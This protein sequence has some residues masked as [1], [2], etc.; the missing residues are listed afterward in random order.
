MYLKQNF[1]KASCNFW[2]ARLNARDV[3]WRSGL[4][5]GVPPR[6]V[7]AVHILVQFAD[8][9]QH[10]AEHAEMRVAAVHLVVEHDAVKAFARRIGQ[11]FF[12]QRHV[13][14]AGKTE[15]VNDFADLVFRGLDA[16][17]NFHLL[18]A[19]QQR[20][21]A[22]LLEIHPHRIIERVQPARVFLLGVGGFDAIHLRLVH[23]F[24]F[25]RAQLGENLVQ[26]FRGHGIFRQ[27]VVEVV[28]GQMPLLLREADEFL[29]FFGK[30]RV[31]TILQKRGGVVSPPRI[32]RAAWHAPQRAV[33]PCSETNLPRVCGPSILTYDNITSGARLKQVEI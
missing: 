12:R 25:Q 18:L 32:P 20:H 19:R 11:Q 10:A 3:R 6:D 33:F 23:D 5:A 9:R 4:E 2:F 21:L 13:F 1:G 28:V 27:H 8:A 29:D 17:G 31:G 16:L 7:V 14:L 24:D 22:H 30:L 15:A 26:N